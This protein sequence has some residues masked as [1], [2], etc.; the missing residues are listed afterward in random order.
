MKS[1]LAILVM[2]L[3]IVAG[4]QE[5]PEEHRQC[6]RK[7]DAQL[8]QLLKEDPALRN[9][10]GP[11][12]LALLKQ[13]S[14]EGMADTEWNTCRTWVTR[15]VSGNFQRALEESTEKANR[16]M[17]RFREEAERRYQQAKKEQAERRKQERARSLQASKRAAEELRQKTEHGLRLRQLEH[18]RALKRLGLDK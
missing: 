9:N 1:L 6:L 12:I 18:E 5:I 16:E 11:I 7:L 3:S 17:D 10:L 4:A 15:R 14:L 13:E 8:A 2:S